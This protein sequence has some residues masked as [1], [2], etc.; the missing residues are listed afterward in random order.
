MQPRAGVSSQRRCS[1][2]VWRFL[3]TW[4][5]YLL[6]QSNTTLM[7]T[8]TSIPGRETER[9]TVP[10]YIANVPPSHPSQVETVTVSSFISSRGV[11]VLDGPGQTIKTVGGV[12]LVVRGTGGTEPQYSNFVT[13]V[14][15]TRDIQRLQYSQLG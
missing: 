2:A 4:P 8:P 12:G 14:P 5:G 7:V 10:T 3:I 15:S 1:T 6:S 9:K 13:W 11:A